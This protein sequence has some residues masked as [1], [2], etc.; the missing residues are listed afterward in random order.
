MYNRIYEYHIHLI[1]H[2]FVLLLWSLVEIY[3]STQ[4]CIKALIIL[5]VNSSL[6]QLCG[7]KFNILYLP[8]GCL[9]YG[10]R[11][12]I[13]HSML[14]LFHPTES[15][16]VVGVKPSLTQFRALEFVLQAWGGNSSLSL[17]K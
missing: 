17:L 6:C 2:S 15:S 14:F 12:L 13:P 10:A 7:F 4:N 11:F 9:H 8:N 3:N 5:Y 16:L 1:F